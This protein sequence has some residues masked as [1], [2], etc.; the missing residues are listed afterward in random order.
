MG[1][2]GQGRDKRHGA[3]DVIM[4]QTVAHRNADP[5][6]LN[7]YGMVIVDEC[8]AVGAPAAE[9]AI[10]QVAVKRWIGLSATPYRADQ[11]DALITMQCGPIRHEITAEVSFAQRLIVHPTDFNT[12]E[13]GN[14]G[15][16]FQAIYGE[17]AANATRTAQIAAD[18]ADAASRGRNSL[19]LTNRME[20]LQCLAAA[21]AG[22]GV[23][24]TLLHGQLSA[25]ERDHAR[26]RLTHTEAGPLVLLAIDKVAGEGFDPAP[27]G[28][29][30]PRDADLVQREGDPARRPDHAR[31]RH[32]ARRRGPRLSGRTSPTVGTHVWQ[33]A[34]HPHPPRLHRHNIQLG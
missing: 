16:S 10:R 27:A 17:L 30:V 14:D 32:Q 11:M 34:S 8:H 22:R 20:H 7:E 6:L 24:A 1:A 25:A 33:A 28:R 2:K 12:D 4:L 3:V 19:I 29:S 18:V 31:S 9:A 21:L 5:S 13:I 15:A 26:T 23:A